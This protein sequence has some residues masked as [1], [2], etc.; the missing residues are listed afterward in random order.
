MRTHDTKRWAVLTLVGA[1]LL[2]LAG[3]GSDKYVATTSLSGANEPTPVTTTANGTATATLENGELTVTGAFSGLQSDLQEVS[4]SAAHVHQG[5]AGTNGGILFNL[6]ITST[7]KR[8]GSFTGKAS[9]DD[10]QQ[11]AFQGGLLYV[12]V[13]TVQN[14]GGEIRG[15]FRPIKQD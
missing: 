1:G 2:V 5:A 6:T 11:T 8:N 3:C 12:N 13:H 9:L 15:Q 4:G 10:E 7:D 14:P